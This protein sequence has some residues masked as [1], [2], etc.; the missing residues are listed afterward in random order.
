MSSEWNQHPR[1]E[2]ISWV[3][4]ALWALAPSF[5]RKQSPQITEDGNL[6]WKCTFLENFVEIC[7][8]AKCLTTHT[9]TQTHNVSVYH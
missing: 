3:L 1:P 7:H 2:G 9:H 6:L 8:W 5:M 4:F